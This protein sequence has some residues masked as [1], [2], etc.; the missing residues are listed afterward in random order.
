ESS[1]RPSAPCCP[2]P[3]RRRRLSP[4]YSP[5]RAPCAPP[6][7]TSPSG[8][9]PPARRRLV[10]VFRACGLEPQA[11]EAISLGPLVGRELL[12]RLEHDEY[13]G[14]PRLRVVGHREL[15]PEGETGGPC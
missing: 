6:S 2:A 12:V 4:T 13:R 8:S 1:P 5:P 3:P 9:H 7:V 11:G 15:E 10:E 14:R